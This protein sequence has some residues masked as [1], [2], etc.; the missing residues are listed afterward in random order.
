MELKGKF[1]NAVIHANDI[2]EN[3]INQIKQLQKQWANDIFKQINKSVKTNG[4]G[5]NTKNVF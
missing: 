3:T 4:G 1:A 2:D 5:R